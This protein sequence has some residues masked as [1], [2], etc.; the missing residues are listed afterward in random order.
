MLLYLC[1]CHV[2]GTDDT[3]RGYVC[4]CSCRYVITKT[5]FPASTTKDRE[6]LVHYT[7]KKRGGQTW[8]SMP[9]KQPGQLR[10]LDTFLSF[11]LTSCHEAYV[12]EVTLFL[13]TGTDVIFWYRDRITKFHI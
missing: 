4:V 13:G 10:L 8:E 2:G 5:L 1:S 3:D 7:L 12:V 6:S 11:P 9:P